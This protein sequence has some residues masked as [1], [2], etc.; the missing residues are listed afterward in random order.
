MEQYWDDGSSA[1]MHMP[2]VARGQGMDSRDY[3]EMT[4][5]TLWNARATTNTCEADSVAQ[6]ATGTENR[7]GERG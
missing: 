3:G 4:N 6:R 2:E 7:G 5:R 1:L